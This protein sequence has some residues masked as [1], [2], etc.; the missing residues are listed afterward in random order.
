MTVYY[1]IS[2]PAKLNLKSLLTIHEGTSDPNSLPI[3]NIL[4]IGILLLF[5]FLLKSVRRST[6]VAAASADP[7]PKPDPIGIFLST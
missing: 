2:A 4:D 1:K 7:P 6:R 5:L 3:C